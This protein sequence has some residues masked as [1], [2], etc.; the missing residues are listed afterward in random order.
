MSR[1]TL[2]GHPLSSY[3][4]KIKIALREKGVAFDAVLP[5]DF[6]TGRRGTPLVAANPRGEVPALI[7]DGRTVFD[8]TV[9]MEFLEDRWPVPALLPA[10]PFASAFAR[11]TGEVCDTHYEAVNWGYGEILWFKRATGGACGTADCRRDAGHRD[12][13][14]LADRTARQRRM[15]RRR[16]VRL[17]GC[18]RGADGQ[19]IGAL[20]V[21]P[22]PEISTCL[23]VRAYPCPP[24][25]RG[26]LQGARRRGG[27]HGRR[28]GALHVGWATPRISR[29]PTGVDDPFG[30]ASTLSRRVSPT[31]LPAFPG[32]APDRSISLMD[33]ESGLEQRTQIK[34]PPVTG[35]GGAFNGGRG[36]D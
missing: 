5:D 15:V 31:T 32:P 10:D 18:G 36:K 26:H 4:Q 16:A 11:E 3:S 21:R 35:T 7:V 23:M 6:G 12:L 28:V 19:A 25:G 13:A 17:G 2:Y 33:R 9:I 22:R 27:T 34:T 1:A 20:R 30:A 24:L 29:S 8:S 14:G